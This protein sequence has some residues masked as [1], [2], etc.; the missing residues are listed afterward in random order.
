MSTAVEILTTTFGTLNE[1]QTAYRRHPQTP[2]HAPQLFTILPQLLE[3]GLSQSESRQISQKFDQLVLSLR[4]EVEA[5]IVRTTRILAACSSSS[6]SDSIARVRIMIEKR[7]WLSVQ[8]T[9]QHILKSVRSLAAKEH[10]PTRLQRRAKKPVF[11]TEFTPLLEG[12]FAS[13]RYPTTQEKAALAKKTGMSFKQIYDWFQNHRNRH[14]EDELTEVQS[15]DSEDLWKLSPEPERENQGR[16]APPA[17]RQRTSQVSIPLDRDTPSNQ[18]ESLKTPTVSLEKHTPSFR[19]QR[20]KPTFDFFSLPTHR[21]WNHRHKYRRKDDFWECLNQEV[22]VPKPSQEQWP[23]QSQLH[24]GKHKRRPVAVDDEF[25]HSFVS[26]LRVHSSSRKRSHDEVDDDKTADF[27]PWSYYRPSSGRHPAFISLDSVRPKRDL[28][29]ERDSESSEQSY[30][31][32][33]YPT[34]GASPYFKHLFTWSTKHDSYPSKEIREAIA[35]ESS[36]DHRRVEDRCIDAQK[37]KSWGAIRQQSFSNKQSQTMD[38][39]TAFPVTSNKMVSQAEE[40]SR[41]KF[42]INTP[43]SQLAE[44]IEGVARG[45]ERQS[46]SSTHPISYS[47]SSDEAQAVGRKRARSHESHCMS[48]DSVGKK[49]MRTTSGNILC[50][51][52]R[53]DT[54]VQAIP[55]PPFSDKLPPET[56]SVAFVKSTMTSGESVRASPSSHCAGSSPAQ[57]HR[58]E[59]VVPLDTVPA[60]HSQPSPFSAS[61]PDSS[62]VESTPCRANPHDSTDP[63]QEGHHTDKECSYQSSN[64]QGSQSLEDS[65]LTFD[66]PASATCE[67]PVG[68]IDASFFMPGLNDIS[69][70]DTAKTVPLSAESKGSLSGDPI[71]DL[72]VPSPSPFDFLGHPITYP[73]SAELDLSLDQL[74]SEDMNQSFFGQDFPANELS[75]SRPSSSWLIENASYPVHPSKDQARRHILMLRERQ[76]RLQQEIHTLYALFTVELDM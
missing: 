42:A 29:H 7:F 72:L 53:P 16:S 31:D 28:S 5:V 60:S 21:E 26:K 8:V 32:E 38:A 19:F 10:P 68:G 43:Q 40:V 1:H 51:H 46:A 65:P 41:G 34:K 22:D 33:N 24:S 4:Q 75:S 30:V 2:S 62:V 18:F 66:P 57:Q 25:N 3:I 67:A 58:P 15:P 69:F 9:Q 6:N 36:C 27:Q 35:P 47:S 64:R 56:E 20:R 44:S 63:V 14:K 76:R 13:N 52:P 50:P 48:T 74:F 37:Q 39:A 70:S 11:K 54:S 49:R 45:I 71:L 55:D 59:P 61:T 12:F 73:I 17:K 23:L